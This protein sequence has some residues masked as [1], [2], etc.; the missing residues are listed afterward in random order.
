M[1]LSMQVTLRRLGQYAHQWADGRTDLPWSDGDVTALSWLE[2][3]YTLSDLRVILER[4]E[5]CIRDRQELT[6]GL[7]L[8]EPVDVTFV[9]LTLR[10]LA[11]W[12]LSRERFR[13]R[14]TAEEDATVRWLASRRSIADLQVILRRPIASIEKRLLRLR[15]DW[16]A[17][18]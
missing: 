13:H 4:S 11:A 14:W 9:Q 10:A 1:A 17:R 2:R 5:S 16:P 12:A 8:I 6:R 15:V 3:R 18:N 7:A